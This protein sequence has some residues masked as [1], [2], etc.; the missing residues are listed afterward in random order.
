MA[1]PRQSAKFV[2]RGSIPEHDVYDQHSTPQPVHAHEEFGHNDGLLANDAEKTALTKE[3]QQVITELTKAEENEA[4]GK[5]TVHGWMHKQGTRKFKG[6]VAKSWRKRYFALEGT[7]IYY[8]HD[9]VDCRKYFSSRSGELAIGAIDLRDAFKLEQSERLDLPARGIAIHTRHR[10]W[11]VCPETET[12]FT[13]WFDALELTIMTAGSGNVIKRELPNVRVYEMKGRSSYRFWYIVF[14]ITALVEL[15]A[16]TLWFPIG[17]EPCDIKLKFAT[18]AEIQDLRVEKLK[19]GAS[20]FNGVWKPPQWYNWSAG[21]SDVKCFRHPSI[22][23][24]VSYF[25]FYFAELI[26]ILL[27]FLYYLGMW[28]PVR[29]GAQYLRD[30][31]PHFPPAKWPTVD[32]L[33]CHYSEPA[34]DTIATLEKIMNLNYPPQLFHVWICDDGYCK[35]K[36][37]EGASVP[38]VGV[39]K[40]V[41]ENAG[42]VRREVAQF[43]F[44]RVCESDDIEV[45]EWRKQHTTVKMPTEANPRVV[46]RA[47]C[48]VGS[49]RD[50]YNY[51]GFPKVTFVGR[52]KPPVHHSKAGNINNVL[53]NEGAC[54]R[55][56][57][58]LDNDMKPHEMFIQ[59]TLPFFFDA[60]RSAKI[61]RC[62]ASGCGD[63]GKICC[64]LCQSAGVPEREI[65]FCSKDCFN[66]SAHVKSSLHRRQTQNTMKE[67]MVCSTCGSKINQKKGVCRKC[68]APSSRRRSSAAALVDVSVD[69]YSDHVSVNQVGYVQTPQYFE[70]CLQLRLGDPCGHRNSTFFD[71]AQTGMD[72]YE[73]ASFAGTNAI[74]RREALDSVCGIQY[75]SLTEDAFTGKMMIDK[76]WKGLYFRKDLEGEESERIRLAEGAVPESVAASLAQRK[77]WAKGNFQIFLRKKDT[78]VDPK[79]T[80]PRVE[81]PKPRKINRFMRWV[82]FMNLTV[83]P[84]GSFPAIFFFYITGHFLYSGNAPIYTSGLRLLMALVPKIVSQSILSAL[85]NRTVENN[86]VL[87][88][89]QTWFSYAFV[90]VLAV[91]EAI[92][93]KITNKEASWANTGALGGNSVMEIPN[94]LV[95]LS[96]VFGI[97][98]CVVRYFTGYNQA[99]TTH[100]TP[101][102]FAS[103]FLG[104]FTAAQ[105]G[106]MVR[107]SFQTYFGWSHKSLTDQGNI[108][109]SFML[110]IVLSILCI[111]VYVETPNHSVFG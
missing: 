36:W 99:E 101:L 37:D 79:W 30:F 28:K 7:T 10:V 65:S 85:S 56:C 57:I 109:G 9:F 81:L 98:W 47:D 45:D 91:F 88:S 17:I 38:K 107:M 62:V 52:I 48:A 6:P 73:C 34:E 49:V 70:D 74:F 66:A 67:R 39:N 61:S 77:R 111:W 68:S 20:P 54:G 55:Y 16:I 46:R 14:V 95:F 102:L 71:S 1:P 19:C 2:N 93:W 80:P 26:S 23:H 51:P 87:R 3:A 11:L 22:S 90:H 84:I 69:E 24:W 105:L 100:G 5:I 32:I 18:C 110:A 42:D 8:F 27:G 97:V 76:G 35:S 106:P 108:V 4:L 21:I 103:L 13:M 104:G 78:M 29:R 92:Y 63:I 44:E 83:Y 75:G 50:D 25:M 59:A 72:G 58:I 60:P 12:D 41:I 64:A 40:G 94:I 15:A 96:M 43:M 86:D 53:Y 89:Q 33:L 31:K 82:F